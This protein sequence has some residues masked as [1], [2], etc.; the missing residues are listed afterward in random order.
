MLFNTLDYAQFFGV[1][2]VASWLLARLRKLRVVLLLVAS[3]VF[4]APWDVRFLPL[5]W[6]SSTADW[7]LGNAI[8]CL[9][10]TSP[11]PR[12]S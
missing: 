9:L 7:L 5:I 12:D 1:V 6:A 2:F 4:Y 10:Y 8:A 11:S 3:Y